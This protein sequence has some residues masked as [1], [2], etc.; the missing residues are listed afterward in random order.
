[1]K[2][3]DYFLESKDVECP[4]C[5]TKCVGSTES[6]TCDHPEMIPRKI[7]NLDR[8]SY[9]RVLMGRFEVVFLKKRLIIHD[10]MTRALRIDYD[11][12]NSEIDLRSVNDDWCVN[13]IIFS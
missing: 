12:L 2:L 3:K 5:L 11:S 8:R 6:K 9:L 7:F 1:M 13:M 10:G 4:F